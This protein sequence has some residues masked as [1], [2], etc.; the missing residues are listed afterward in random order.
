MLRIILFCLALL[1]A[2]LNA[3]GGNFTID[4]SVDKDK[5]ELGEALRFTLRMHVQGSLDF[6]PQMEQ[7]KF[8]G[9]NAQGPQQGSNVQ[10]ING[11]VSMDYSWTWELVP[12]KSGTLTLGPYVAKAKDA[13]A[14]EIIRQTKAVAV[15]VR[16]PKQLALNLGNQALPTPAAALEPGADELRDIKP[17][18]GLGWRFW[19]ALLVGLLALAGFAAWW[20][21]WRKP[22]PKEEAKPRDPA[23][24]ALLELE[25]ARQEC[26]PGGESIYVK[27]SAAV[28]RAFLRHRLDLRNEFT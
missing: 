27:R 10:W 2:G 22:K 4:A 8:E 16:R 3:A 7:P 24:H 26:G 23:Q 15:K 19:T 17:D 13:K 20:F 6:P 14:G 28:L 5:V 12:M 1:P 21:I 18:R 25:L 9:F 11:Q